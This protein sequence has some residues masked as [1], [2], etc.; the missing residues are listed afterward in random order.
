MLYEVIT[1]S[2]T[3]YNFGI[4]YS[5]FGNYS[6][7]GQHTFLGSLDLIHPSE[8]LT[9]ELGLDLQSYMKSVPD[10]AGTMFSYRERKTTLIKVNPSVH[11]GIDDIEFKVGVCMAS[12]NDFNENNFF[13]APD[14]LMNLNI[15]ESYNFV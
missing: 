7:V 4:G 5:A 12:I 3:L 6:G 10:S 1:R 14:I 8:V 2:S 9:F 15:V 11:F 13:I